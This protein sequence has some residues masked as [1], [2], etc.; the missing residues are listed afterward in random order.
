MLYDFELLI[1]C[2]IEAN[3]KI[4]I[5]HTT[6]NQILTFKQKENETVKQCIDRLK[7]YIARCPVNELPSE[8]K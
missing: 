1:K 5:K 2:F 6:A 4:G 3:T 8:E 7:Q